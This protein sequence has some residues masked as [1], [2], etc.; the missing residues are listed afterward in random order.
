MSAG[1]IAVDA[2]SW[3]KLPPPGSGWS[4][5]FDGTGRFDVWMFRKEMDPYGFRL[6]LPLWFLPLVTLLPTV[7][8]WRL[9]TLAHRRARL[10][11]CP[12]CNY[13]RTGLAP[14]AICPECGTAPAAP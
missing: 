8:A 12:T 13:N 1:G 2:T 3:E 14:R 5:G 9:D 6:F 10:N 11:L 7:L 4:G